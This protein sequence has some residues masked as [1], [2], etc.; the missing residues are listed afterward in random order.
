MFA[1]CILGPDG[2]IIGVPDSEADELH[3][4]R[5]AGQ[6][7]LTIASRSAARAASPRRNAEARASLDMHQVVA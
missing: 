5:T 6:T 1:S 4:Q 2:A 7:P 3:M